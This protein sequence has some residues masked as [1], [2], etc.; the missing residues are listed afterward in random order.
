MPLEVKHVSK[1]SEDELRD[2]PDQLKASRPWLVVEDGMRAASCSTQEEAEEALA[3]IK[4]LSYLADLVE[5][6]IDEVISRIHVKGYTI[7]E[8][9][10]A[11]R[12][13]L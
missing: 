2:F 10:I 4:R 8:V 3:K 9:R 6:E 11:I 1:C 5:E 13:Y 7:S 12:E